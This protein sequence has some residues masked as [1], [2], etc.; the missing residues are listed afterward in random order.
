[1][2]RLAAAVVVLA[3]SSSVVA[4]AQEPR[5]P[6]GPAKPAEPGKPVEPTKPPDK[7]QSK[8]LNH[9]FQFGLA[10]R[11]GTGYRVI[12]PYH[13]EFCGEM[14]NATEK[15]AVCGSRQRA[16]LELSPSFGITRSLELLVDVRFYL[17][18]DWTG[19]RAYFFAPGIKYYTDPDGL[20]KF[21]ATFQVGFETQDYSGHPQA[22][23][24]SNFDVAI[25]SAFGV[26][27]DLIRHVGLFA[28][29]G[30]ILGMSRWLTF[31]ADFAGGV[32]GRF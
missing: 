20:F 15:K 28:Q 3:L 7:A 14:A 31:V 17:E 10:V 24:V 23:T 5:A 1:M 18:E 19:T 9:R 8:P 21:F 2:G 13:D 30:V 4:E 26:H 11:A 12:A 25:R 22:A 29:G 16:W 27:F 6:A 32:Q